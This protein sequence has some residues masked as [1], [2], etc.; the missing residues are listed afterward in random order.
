MQA[1]RTALS[2]AAKVCLRPRFTNCTSWTKTIAGD[3]GLKMSLSTSAYRP[4]E[5]EKNAN[6]LQPNFNYR[7]GRADWS[8]TAV[9]SAI[10][11]GALFTAGIYGLHLQSKTTRSEEK[12]KVFAVGDDK[13][14]VTDV[15]RLD[16]D[17]DDKP[18][19]AAEGNHEP[20]K[21]TAGSEPAD[22]SPESP[23]SPTPAV[24][25]P[26]MATGT[27]RENGDERPRQDPDSDAL[28]SAQEVLAP[29]IKERKAFLVENITPPDD[30][31]ITESVQKSSKPADILLRLIFFICLYFGWV[32]LLPKRV[33]YE[34]Y[35]RGA[36]AMKLAESR[37]NAAFR[38]PPQRR[39]PKFSGGGG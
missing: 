39:G 28:G 17:T 27:A 29:F 5:M 18:C 23:E 35:S 6:C 3:Q 31:A 38:K 9:R 34:A 25:K 2:V 10:G 19:G 32:R 24:E 11:A 7:S 37:Q 12:F 33:T 36:D 22:V 30:N 21:P 20:G 15:R 14:D 13:S 1:A 8:K 26:E 4:G 16:R